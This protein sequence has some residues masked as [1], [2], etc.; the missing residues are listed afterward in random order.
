MM[1]A[2]GT[3]GLTGESDRP[4]AGEFRDST[5][6]SDGIRLL[7]RVAIALVEC[8]SGEFIRESGGEMGNS[9]RS[10]LNFDMVRRGTLD[11]LRIWI[12][13]VGGGVGPKR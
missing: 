5:R 7:R 4:P 3:P 13:C 6:R 1:F 2:T 12:G 9:G 10:S 8:A 11:G